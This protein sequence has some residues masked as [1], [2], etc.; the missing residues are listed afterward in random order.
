MCDVPLPP[1]Y[2]PRPI[3]EGGLLAGGAPTGGSDRC[4]LVGTQVRPAASHP[5]RGADEHECSGGVDRRDHRAGT[6][7]PAR[8]S[9]R[10][11]ATSGISG[12]WPLGSANPP[13]VLAAHLVGQPPALHRRPAGR[14]RLRARPRQRS[15]PAG[16]GPAPSSRRHRG[17]AWHRPGHAR[18]LPE[19]ELDREFPR[20]WPASTSPTGDFLIHLTSHLA[21]HLGQIDSHRRLLTGGGAVGRCRFRNC[22]APDPA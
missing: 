19:A 13:G 7:H 16:T 4:H 3:H 21:Y 9:S 15:S 12:S 10:P 18:A 5:N 20:S 17:D 1:V 6:P 2:G 22:R 8:R 11:T 14:H